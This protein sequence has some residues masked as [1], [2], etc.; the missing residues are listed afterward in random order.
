M[1]RHHNELCTVEMNLTGV[2]KILISKATTFL[3]LKLKSHVEK[4][5]LKLPPKYNKDHFSFFPPMECQPSNW[6]TCREQCT[7]MTYTQSLNRITSQRRR[8]I[9]GKAQ[10]NR[11]ARGQS[12]L[13]N[14]PLTLLH[15]I[16]HPL[17][18]QASGRTASH[19]V[20]LWKSP[21]LDA[22][23]LLVKWPH[24]TLLV[25]SSQAPMADSSGFSRVEMGISYIHSYIESEDF[26]QGCQ[27]FC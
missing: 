21:V 3:V 22:T 11:P 16:T 15:Q 24:G 20:C 6:F 23:P 8:L 10:G 7:K 25:A 4:K 12:S 17:S 5:F 19:P 13:W 14:F 2:R 27:R 9:P 26:Q 18:L 1:K